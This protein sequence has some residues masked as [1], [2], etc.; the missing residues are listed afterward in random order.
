[1]SL[2]MIHECDDLVTAKYYKK[3]N[4][5]ASKAMCDLLLNYKEFQPL[6]RTV[7]MGMNKFACPECGAY[8]DRGQQDKT[9]GNYYYCGNCYMVFYRCKRAKEEAFDVVLQFSIRTFGNC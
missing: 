7:Y 2:K 4:E 5:F 1:M 3:R 6:L 9:E 8:I